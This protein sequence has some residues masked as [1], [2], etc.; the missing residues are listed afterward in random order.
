M[1]MNIRKERKS[2]KMINDYSVYF[3]N[4]IF[5]R[6]RVFVD[7]VIFFETSGKRSEQQDEDRDEAARCPET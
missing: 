4:G 6:M 2:S 1:S 3:E 7:G 5:P